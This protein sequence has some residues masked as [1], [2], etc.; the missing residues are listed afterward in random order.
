MQDSE[1][2]K[3]GDMAEIDGLGGLTGEDMEL[4]FLF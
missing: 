4:F 1:T 3:D 2:E